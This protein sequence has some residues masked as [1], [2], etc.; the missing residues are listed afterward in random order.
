MERSD[1]PAVESM[2]RNPEG[3]GSIPRLGSRS[4]ALS[5]LNYCVVVFIFNETI[6]SSY[7]ITQKKMQCSL[8]AARKTVCHQ[9]GC[10]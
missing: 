6:K 1:G 7:K 2:S 4:S 5:T 10:L 3:R 9:A 8:K